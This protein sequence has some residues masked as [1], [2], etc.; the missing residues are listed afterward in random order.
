MSAWRIFSISVQSSWRRFIPVLKLGW[1]VF[2]VLHVLSFSLEQIFDHQ[3][4]LVLSAGRENW[5]TLA[6]LFIGSS[7]SEL[8]MTNLWLIAIVTLVRAPASLS[9]SQGPEQVWL[10]ATTSFNALLVESIRA[11]ASVLRW[12]PLLLVPGLIRYLQ[13]LFV[14]YVVLTNPSY[15]QG[16]VDALALSTQLSKGRWGLLL[17]CLLLVTLGPYLLGLPVH[18]GNDSAFENLGPTLLWG[19]LTLFINLFCSLFLFSIFENLSTKVSIG[20]SHVDFQLDRHSP[21]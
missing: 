19:F 18:G 1:P 10:A 6:P 16:Q 20:D 3:Q 15:S 13:F 5:S 14:P 9:F 11:L 12:I 21:A 2:I 17:V 7:L 8:F 4:N